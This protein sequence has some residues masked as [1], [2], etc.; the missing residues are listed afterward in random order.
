MIGSDDELGEEERAA[1][2]QRIEKLAEAHLQG[3]PLFILSASLKGPLDTGWKNPWKKDRTHKNT[4][5][6]ERKIQDGKQRR[7]L[8]SPEKVVKETDPQPSRFL[9]S[10]TA[11]QSPVSVSSPGIRWPKAP[12]IR[13]S[14]SPT[15]KGSRSKP[16]SMRSAL[17]ENRPASTSKFFAHANHDKLRPLED[18]T[19]DGPGSTDW[20]KRDG[21]RS[22]FGSMNGLPSSPTPKRS[23]NISNPEK[24]PNPLS[25][26][27]LKG[28]KQAPVDTPISP[29][30]RNDLTTSSFNVVSSTSQLPRFEYRK[31]RRH[32]SSP[33]PKPAHKQQG[34][35]TDGSNRLLLTS[36]S[37][38]PENNTTGESDVEM[39]DAE[40]EEEERPPPQKDQTLQLSK[41]LRFATDTEGAPST[42][43]EAQQSTEQSTYPELPSAQVL[44]GPLGVSDRVPSL[45]STA[46]PKESTDMSHDTTPDTQLS[47][48]A[49]LLHAQRS[50]Q[51]DLDSPNNEL[52]YTPLGRRAMAEAGNDSL[53]AQETPLYRPGTSERV[54][55]RSFRDIERDRVQAMST[56][57]MIDAVSPFNFSTEKK[58]RF[59]QPVS[60]AKPPS[61]LRPND[62]ETT[63]DNPIPSQVNANPAALSKNASPPLP[64]SPSAQPSHVNTTKSATQATSLPFALSGST[65]TTAQDGQGAESFDCSQAIADA[66]S[67]LQQSLDFM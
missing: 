12:L 49:A 65:P 16:T 1:K 41:S 3:R 44:S 55:P 22:N 17:S 9:K 56:Q 35:H 36:V 38:V 27:L 19:F 18:H 54:V 14:A 4:G 42:Y 48:Q 63:E 60:P 47:T 45:H 15:P 61:N 32:V 5:R 62:P 26:E 50:F 51:D 67:W 33:G 24:T 23:M 53:L 11:E 10:G 30:K 2:R 39:A 57:N 52:G 8:R 31:H 29:T 59:H 6:A 28:G 46:V 37:D 66:G 43:S 7:N 21:K 40:P 34:S 20:L 13:D 64:H 58:Q 25:K